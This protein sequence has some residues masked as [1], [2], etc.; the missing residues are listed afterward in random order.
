MFL[1]LLVLARL[2]RW[3]VLPLSWFRDPASVTFWTCHLQPVV[4]KVLIPVCMKK[5]KS[6]E[7]WV[8]RFLWVRAVTKH[9]SAFILLARTM[10]MTTPNHKDVWE[11]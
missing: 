2:N 9:R 11:R 3:V 6:V 1:F 10:D 5:G 4:S 8:G 7:S